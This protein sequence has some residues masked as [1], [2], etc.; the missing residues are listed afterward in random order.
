[1]LGVNVLCAPTTEE[2]EY[3]AGPG[4]LAIARLRQGKADV[5][6]TPE[7]AAAHSAYCRLQHLRES[8]IAAR[9][10][11]RPSRLP[12]CGHLHRHEGE[13]VVMRNCTNGRYTAMRNW[14][15][16]C[17]NATAAVCNTRRRLILSGMI[18]PQEPFPSAAL[19]DDHALDRLAAACSE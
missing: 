10:A 3:L 15:K 6:P 2:A 16:R 7:E 4:A 11:E 19:S 18:P 14:C 1:M 8:D 9:W 5:Y 17:G 12:G 13:T